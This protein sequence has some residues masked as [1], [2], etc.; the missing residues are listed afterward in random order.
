MGEKVEVR[1]E[2]AKRLAGKRIVGERIPI[3]TPGD[4]KPCVA[5]MPDGELVLV[6]FFPGAFWAGPRYRSRE[7]I[8]LFRSADGGVTWKGPQNLTLEKGLLGREPYFTILSD[9]TMLITVHFLIDDARNPAGYCRSFVHRSSDGGKTWTTTTI[10]PPKVEQGQSSVTTRNV[11]EMQDGT[12]LVGVSAEG[13]ENSF[14]WRSRAS[15]RTW[16]EEYPSK[17]DGVDESYPYCFFG[18]GHWWQARSGKVYLVE[19][20][21]GRY[22]AKRFGDDESL[23][24]GHS[25]HYDRMVVFQT[26]DLGRTLT[27]VSTLGEIG[28]M[29]PSILRLADGRLLFT[30]T[31]RAIREPLGVRAVLGEELEDGFRFDCSHDR[32][33]LDG[34]TAPGVTSGGGFGPTVQLDDGML[35]T[36]YSWRDAE[37]ITHLEVL[38]WRL[39]H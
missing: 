27:P 20:L 36:S 12:L 7:E 25:D 1:I 13:I 26:T 30:F 24:Q 4:Y 39:P 37:H 14:I 35:V 31:V 8:L 33:V 29:Y 15:G 9:G 10:E 18:E 17:I 2:E 22:C 6:A 32:L 34:Q 5:K 38:R 11:L 19:R 21:N 23:I 16:R 28:N 3:G